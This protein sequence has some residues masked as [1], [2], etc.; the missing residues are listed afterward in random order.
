MHSIA[1]VSSAAGAA[2]Y[3][4]NDNY[5]TQDDAEPGEWFGKGAEALGLSG[6]VDKATFEKLLGGEL[7]D[8]TKVGDVKNRRLGLDLTFS[9]PKSVSIMALVAGDKRLVEAHKTAVKAAVAYIEAHHAEARN[10]SRNPNGEAEKTGN[11]IAA[12]YTHDTS[13]ALDPNLHGHAVT[14]NATQAPDGSWKALWNQEIWK[15]NTTIG[16]VYHA[17]LRNLVE[18]LGYIVEAVGKHGTFEIREVPRE[19]RDEYSTRRHDILEKTAELGIESPEGRNRVVINTRDAKLNIEDRPALIQSWRDRLTFD[20][21]A[22]RDRA[23]ARADL[24]RRSPV[25][26]TAHAVFAEMKARFAA[27]SGG[28][29]LLTAGIGALRLSAADIRAEHA[30]ASAV[31]HLSEREAAFKTSHLL[32][33][34]LN[35][36]VKGVEPGAVIARIDQLI[37]Q[38]TLIPGTSGRIDGHADMVTTPQ[39]LQMETAILERIASAADQGRIYA[40]PETAAQR[41]QQAASAPGVA[42]EGKAGWMLNAGQLAAGIAILASPERH[43][44]VQGVAGAGKST[45][46]GA[47]NAVLAGDGIRFLGLAFQ[48]KMVADLRDA[49]LEA[50]TIAS[51]T[52]QY[53]RAA[54]QPGSAAGTNSRAELA[55]TLIV[56][57]EASMVSTRDME[58]LTFIAERLKLDK[59]IFMGDRQQLSAIEQGKMFAASQAA[60]TTTLRMDENIRQ[61]NSPLLLAVSALSNAGYA[62]HA[63]GL[64]A[65]HGRVTEAGANHIEATADRWIGLSAEARERTAIFTAGR[66][67]RNQIN[68][69]VQEALKAEGKLGGEGHAATVLQSANTTREELRYA[70]TY[71]SGQIL[72]AR[73][74]VRELGLGRGQ[75]TVTAIAGDGKIVLAG[76]DGKER[77]IDPQQ[78]DARHRYDRLTLH[79]VKR[80]TLH[81]GETIF[82]REKHKDLG[83]DKS[84]Y[85]KVV[86]ADKD[87]VTIELAKGERITLPKGHA[88][89]ER[90]DLGYALNAHM[91]Q[92]MT[93]PEAIEHI[94]SNQTHLASQRTQNV[95]NTRATE[96]MHVVTDDVGRL[97]AQLDRTPGDKTSALET[98]GKLQIDKATPD[99]I[100]REHIRLPAELKDRIAA[101]GSAK[102]PSLPVPEKQLGLEL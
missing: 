73:M 71:R 31:R 13:R 83:I 40:D 24:N 82:W 37:A 96:D 50:R 95:L 53:I 97:K 88:M 34:A 57:D 90:L 94:A 59:L 16:Q 49:G 85:A 43:L 61:R 70:A 51:F 55:N 19:A 63:I 22:L 11:L 10:Y 72:E 42:R 12:I 23:I 25:I 35:L 56:V 20:A 64:L 77:R 93:K 6:E 32:A 9:A 33:A 54:W 87:H 74:G 1:A 18:T 60:G 44:N 76:P 81:D 29:P 45:L 92:G 100:A 78:I 79:D 98:V 65:Q 99:P 102:P 69:L 26:E 68:R 80:L 66:D 101:L 36:Q 84:T 3:F 47:V 15:N 27:L 91:V 8:G 58:R 17:V 86:T 14:M 5:Y 28:D 75:Y 7:P 62:S 21:A 52:N 2:A 39:S 4:N 67:D 48:N 41:L 30:T 89:L 38:G 46:L